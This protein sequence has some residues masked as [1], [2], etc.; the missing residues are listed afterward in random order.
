MLAKIRCS[1]VSICLPHL[2]PLNIQCYSP[3]SSA[4]SELEDN[5]G[6]DPILLKDR[7][8]FVHLEQQIPATQL[9]LWS[10]TRL[11]P[12]PLLFVPTSADASLAGN[13]GV[14]HHQYADDTQVYVALCVGL[15]TQRC[16]LT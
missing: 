9:P 8:Q 13:F 15:L 2:T 3:D 12:C 5:T 4:V 1:S 11:R 6:M 7:T 10:A 14:G 16:E